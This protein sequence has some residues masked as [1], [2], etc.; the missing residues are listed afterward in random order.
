MTTA[1]SFAARVRL[2]ETNARGCLD[3]VALLVLF[4]ARAQ[5]ACGTSGCRTAKS[6]RA[7]SMR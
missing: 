1:G 6:L 7:D 5:T 4:E 3:D 2:S